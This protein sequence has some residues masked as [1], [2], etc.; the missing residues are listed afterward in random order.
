MKVRGAIGV[1]GFAIARRPTARNERR[2]SIVGV[3]KREK[4]MVMMFD[5]RPSQHCLAV[6]AARLLLAN[7]LALMGQYFTNG[8][9]TAQDTCIICDTE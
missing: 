8:G 1:M 4:L 5:L 2:R 6:D 9:D 7:V 3:V